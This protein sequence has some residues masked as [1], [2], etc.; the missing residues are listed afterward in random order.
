[1]KKLLLLLIS[2]CFGST[3]F[4]QDVYDEQV[5]IFQRGRGELIAIENIQAG[6]STGPVLDACYAGLD[7]LEEELDITGIAPTLGARLKLYPVQFEE[8]DA[9][10]LAESGD[11]SDGD[12]EYVP[13]GD[14]PIWQK[15]VTDTEPVEAIGEMLICQDWVSYFPGGNLVPVYYEITVGDMTYIAAG[16]GQSPNFPNLPVL[17]GGGQFLAP[18]FLGGAAGF[19]LAGIW[20]MSFGATIYPAAPVGEV[21]PWYPPN[22]GGA[23]T[24][25]ALIDVL[26]LEDQ[27]ESDNVITIRTYTPVND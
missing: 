18:Q 3:V 25:N 14:V 5:R 10:L 23:L 11:D 26:G 2:L 20:L 27:F 15:P 17:P 6:D 22:F 21:P 12:R 4:A 13:T 24:S 1:M 16:A 8:T 7:V 9:T 19:P